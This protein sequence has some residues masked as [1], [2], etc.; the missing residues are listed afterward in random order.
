MVVMRA[1]TMRLAHTFQESTMR[2]GLPVNKD[3]GQLTYGGYLK[4]NDLLNLQQ[5]HSNPPQH[6]E[7]LFIIIHQVYE[8]WFKQMLH[9][10]DTIIEKLNR[11]DVLGAIRLI[12]RG[13]E[14]QRVLVS[15]VAVLETMTPMDFLAFRDNL[16]PA[17]GFQS[18]QFREFEFA[19]GLKDESFLNFFT[20][21]TPEYQRLQN[22]LRE[23]GLP[24]A[25]F[26]LLRRRAFDTPEKTPNESPET[27]H[28]RV[29]SLMSIYQ[30]AEKNYDLFLLAESLIEFDEAV[31]L[32]RLRHVK[33]AERMI[34]SK[35]GT[36]GS[37][38]VAYLQSTT[39]Q[40]F[41]PELWELRTYL[42]NATGGCPMHGT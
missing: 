26:A 25:L 14:I 37:E 24:D 36:G 40:K 27:Y 28:R 3:E 41:F 9:E 38:G 39:T 8:L 30:E 22:R 2:F 17:S 11:D 31:I 18:T 10:I 6:D 23:P 42:S 19:C 35:I 1:W 13:I 29:A 12:R 32:W 33:M 21:G 34:G 5:L 16:M 4:V 20:E 15:Q 7:T